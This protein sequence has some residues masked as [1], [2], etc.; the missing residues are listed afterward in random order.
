MQQLL[1]FQLRVFLS[2]FFLFCYGWMYSMSPEAYYAIH[3]KT[4]SGDTTGMHDL[5]LQKADLSDFYL[6][7]ARGDYFFVSGKTTEALDEYLHALQLSKNTDSL[8]AL[9]NYKVG[10]LYCITDNYSQSLPYLNK[11]SLIVNYQPKN[12]Q[13]ARLYVYI[14]L[15]HHFLGSSENSKKNYITA[16]EFF[17]KKNDLKKMASTKNNIALM[18]L[19]DK[20]FDTAQKY[21]DSCLT[22]RKNLNDHYGMGQSYNNIGTLYF[23]KEEFKKAL[24]YYITGYQERITGKAP[25]SGL[26][27]SMINIGKTYLKLNDEKNAVWWLEEG[28]KMAEAENHYELKRRASEHLKDLYYQQKQFQKAFEMQELYYEA[29]DSLFG[30]DKKMAI[31]NATLQNHFEMKIRQD[32][33]SNAEKQIAENMVAEEKEKRNSVVFYSLAGGMVFLLFF[34]YQLFRTNRQRKKTNAIIVQQKD[35]LDQKQKEIVDSINYA[36]KIQMALLA[37]DELLQKN[38]PEHFIFYQPKDIVSGDFYWG[39]FAEATVPGGNDN[40]YLAVCD[41][42]G[43]GVPG[44]FMSLLNTSFLN[45]AINEKNISSPDKVFN[46][47]RKRLIENITHEGARDGMDGVLLC[48]SSP[49]PGRGAGS[50]L[51]S[52]LAE[53]G[54][55]VSYAA[56]N[57]SPVIIRNNT[58]IDLPCDKMPVGKGH[59]EDDFN[60]FTI[61]IEKGDMLYLFTDG[62]ADQFGGE[63]HDVSKAGGKKFKKTNLKKLFLQLSAFPVN[64]QKSKLEETFRSWCGDLEQLDDICIIGIRF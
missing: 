62:F 63:N 1:H 20:E 56:A 61:I 44:A 35:A 8:F 57:N 43:H 22:I 16:L 19:E 64:E 47:I 25:A 23:E 34:I 5:L 42:T 13:Q 55:E 12:F 38:L 53:Q 18:Y 50:P 36:K 26:T 4:E 58:I 48:I 6:S 24:E 59:R 11:A 10:Y 45:E 15:V 21:F 60:L 46:H 37:H 31:E 49:L 41:S 40:F 2:G 30:Y 33:I 7:L 32:S 27:E 51:R 14:G 17:R 52:A 29:K 28:L 9:A 54:G 39:T 3:Y